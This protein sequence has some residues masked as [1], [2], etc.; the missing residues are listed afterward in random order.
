MPAKLTSTLTFLQKNML[1]WVF[2]LSCFITVFVAQLCTLIGML[3]H[4]FHKNSCMSQPRT[5][6]SHNVQK[7]S[8]VQFTFAKFLSKIKGIFLIQCPYH[9]YSIPS[10][11]PFILDRKLAK[12]NCTEDRF[13]TSCNKVVHGLNIYL[14]NYMYIYVSTSLYHWTFIL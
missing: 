5:T 2:L 10:K 14:C 1:T 11:I 9:G 4:A 8:S 13:C 3:S 6:L 12:A 7:R